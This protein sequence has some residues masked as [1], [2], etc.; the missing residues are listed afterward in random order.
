MK[1]RIHIQVN[2][3]LRQFDKLCRDCNKGVSVSVVASLAEVT[4]KMKYNPENVVR[5]SCSQR[6]LSSEKIVSF[7]SAFKLI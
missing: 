3:Q 5:D 7:R 1:R 4:Y 6:G 2:N